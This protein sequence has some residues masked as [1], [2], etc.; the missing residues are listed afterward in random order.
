MRARVKSSWLAVGESLWF[1]PAV[2]T[3][4]AIA[5]AVTLVRLDQV[6]RLDRR[7]DAIWWLVGGGADGTRGVLSAIAGTMITVTG[8]V[9]SITIVALQLA[10]SQFSPRVLRTFTGDRG[11]Q[12]VLAAF[13]GAFTY[14][15]V[16]S[17]SIAGAAAAG[18]AF[19]PSAAITGAL[20]L[21]FVALGCSSTSSTTSPR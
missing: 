14:A 19:V 1:V 21:V 18:G 13:I 16:V 15:M 5:L 7:A 3:V 8:V 11:N 9:F 20:L 17:G 4:L 12:I 10:S 2:C 6:L